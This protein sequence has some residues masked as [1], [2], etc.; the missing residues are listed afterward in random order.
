MLTFSTAISF[1]TVDFLYYQKHTNV[2]MLDT[3]PQGYLTLAELAQRSGVTFRTV[4]NW[5]ASGKVIGVYDQHAKR[6]L[7]SEAEFERV[8]TQGVTD[9]RRK[10]QPQAV[11]A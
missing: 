8:Q 9:G 3:K 5:L 4:Q 11:E 2:S 6:W 1:C 7:V 10:K